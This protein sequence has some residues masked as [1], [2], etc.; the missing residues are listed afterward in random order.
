MA[1][2]LGRESPKATGLSKVGAWRELA[3]GLVMPAPWCC[4]LW[5]GGWWVPQ[6][7]LLTAYLGASPPASFPAEP[8]AP[9]VAGF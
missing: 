3:S 6:W 9:T 4:G 2:I 8:S 5:G 1:V 7:Q